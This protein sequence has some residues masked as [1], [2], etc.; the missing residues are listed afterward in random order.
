MRDHV[1]KPLAEVTYCDL[2]DGRNNTASSLLV[3]GALLGMGARICA[4]EP[5]RP[6]PAVGAIA[7]GLAS[8]S[9]ARLTPA[10]SR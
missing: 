6:S 7:R 10:R 2:G 8:G 1:H 9:G 5:L 4:P 3:T